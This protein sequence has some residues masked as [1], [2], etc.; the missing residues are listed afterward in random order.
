MTQC[1]DL[2]N[3]HHE[4]LSDIAV[5]TLEKFMKNELEEELPDELRMVRNFNKHYLGLSNSKRGKTPQV[6]EIYT[7]QIRNKP[8]FK[9]FDKIFVRK[10]LPTWTLFWPIFYIE[11]PHK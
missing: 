6:Y 4:K 7:E 11:K 5:V 3:A 8:C 1:R 9:R 10:L 2:E